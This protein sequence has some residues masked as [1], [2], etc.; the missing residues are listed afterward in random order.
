MYHALKK[1]ADANPDPATGQNRD[2]S[3]TFRM[4]A[5]PSYLA[6]AD[7][8]IVAMPVSSGIGGGVQQ[9]LANKHCSRAHRDEFGH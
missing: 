6:S 5:V 2:I 4:E 8:K 1:M 3:S 9:N 7:G